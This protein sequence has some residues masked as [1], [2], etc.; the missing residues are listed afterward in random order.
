MGC[1]WKLF[2]QLLGS[3]LKREDWCVL[4]WW[5]TVDMMVRVAFLDHE[6]EAVYW[7]WQSNTLEVWAPNDRELPFQTWTTYPE[8]YRRKNEACMVAQTVKKLP[9]M[10]ETWIW[11][12]S[13][14][15]PQRREW[16][17][18]LVSLP[19]EF[20]GQRNLVGCYPWGCKELDRNERLTLLLPLHLD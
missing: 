4:S 3:I 10:Q 17:H 16:Q 20:Y 14:E 1:K 18:T 15:D 6:L 9:A 13:R 5:L 2:A 7:R 19:G 12:L 8:F 11:S